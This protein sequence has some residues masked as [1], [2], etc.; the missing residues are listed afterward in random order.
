MFKEA[1][2]AIYCENDLEFESCVKEN[3]ELLTA[4]ESP[5]LLVHYLFT[6]EWDA[7]IEIY[8][9]YGGSFSHKTSDYAV[10]LN[11]VPLSI[12][13]GQTILHIVASKRD[14]SKLNRHI[15]DYPLLNI[16][17][18][19]GN[20]PMDI[21]NE[22]IGYSKLAVEYRKDQHNKIIERTRINLRDIPIIPVVFTD[23]DLILERPK[24]SV[25]S[26]GSAHLVESEK[27]VCDATLCEG[28]GEDGSSLP[29]GEAVV[30]A[31]GEEVVSVSCPLKSSVP[32][33]IK[34]F[35]ISDDLRLHLLR[36]IEITEEKIPNSMH[37]YGKI[38]GSNLQEI[39]KGVVKSLL[40]EPLHS[41]IRNIHSFYVKYENE[42]QFSLGSH[43]DDSTFTINIC[44]NN[45]STG[46]DLVFDDA[47]IRY[48]HKTGVGIIHLGIHRHHVEPIISGS[49]ENVIIWVTL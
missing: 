11:K 5:Y 39:V 2:N 41:R 45:N 12:V 25:I 23:N 6:N 14:L 3:P 43:I 7:G 35:S 37:R 33:G 9:K 8:K 28:S 38:L 22:P 10:A 40:D 1:L 20:T 46:T 27:K 47:G 15:E 44:L 36:E 42:K 26:N 18:F 34:T 49:R 32:N 48:M 13:G 29:L 4:H 21:L 31:F 16:T 19:N 24:E 17:D 30:V